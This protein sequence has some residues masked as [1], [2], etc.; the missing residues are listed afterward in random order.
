MRLNLLRPRLRGGEATPNARQTLSE[1]CVGRAAADTAEK[2]QARSQRGGVQVLD[3]NQSRDE[4]RTIRRVPVERLTVTI[5]GSSCGVT[6]KSAGA[7]S[8]AGRVISNGSSTS[9]TLRFTS[10][11][12]SG[13]TASRP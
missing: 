1:D 10:R 12:G 6:P 3:R 7:R 8:A 13:T 9:A 2:D 11:A 5:A 4:H